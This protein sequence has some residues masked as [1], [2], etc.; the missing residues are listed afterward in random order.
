M[1]LFAPWLTN[2][3]AQAPDC[4]PITVTA[5]TPWT[6]NFENFYYTEGITTTHKPSTTTRPSAWIKVV[7]TCIRLAAQRRKTPM[8]LCT[9]TTGLLHR[10]A[11]YLFNS[12][13]DTTAT[14]PSSSCLSFPT[15]SAIL[16]FRSLLAVPIPTLVFC[17][18]VIGTAVS[19]RHFTTTFLSPMADV[20]PILRR[21][22][23]T[24][25][26]LFADLSLSWVLPQVPE[27]LCV[28]TTPMPLQPRVAASI[29]MTF[30]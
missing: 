2:V 24:L 25:L 4:S 15:R 7:G 6:E 3:R 18:W 30:R 26:A 27:S 22:I 9:P 20:S 23:P 29:S 16:S 11:W 19:L 8:W 1:A 13:T 28:I 5:S 21:P 17:K 14:A 10:A 12:S